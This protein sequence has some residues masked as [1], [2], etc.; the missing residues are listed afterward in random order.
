MEYCIVRGRKFLLVKIECPNCKK[1]RKVF[2]DNVKK[3]TFT[4][5]CSKCS[6]KKNLPKNKVGENNPLWKGGRR[7]LNTG[8]IQVWIPKDDP[9]Y[10]M[11]Y[12]GYILEHRYIIAKKI[13][14]KLESWEQVD[15]INNNRSDNREENL[16]LLSDFSHSQITKM[17]VKIRE[18]ENKLL[19]YE[20]TTIL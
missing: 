5:R 16:Q 18:L 2:K 10:E 8:Y 9:F 15:H 19:K 7:I 20:H 13:G 12:K 14:R 3:K 1:K 17:R 6:S 4:G 11:S